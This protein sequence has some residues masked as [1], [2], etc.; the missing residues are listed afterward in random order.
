MSQGYATSGVPLQPFGDP[1]CAT[2]DADLLGRTFVAV[3]FAVE[4]LEHHLGRVGVGYVLDPLA[5]EPHAVPDDEDARRN[6]IR[7]RISASRDRQ[8]REYRSETEENE[9]SLRC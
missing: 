5:Y 4:G 8:S 6:R 9:G 1:D 2:D 7:E 3:V